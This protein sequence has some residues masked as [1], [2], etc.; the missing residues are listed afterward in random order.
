MYD[1]KLLQKPTRGDDAVKGGAGRH[2]L[3]RV[4]LGSGKVLPLAKRAKGGAAEHEAHCSYALSV[5]ATSVDKCVQAILFGAFG[6]GHDGWTSELERTA[7]WPTET[8]RFPMRMCMSVDLH[9]RDISSEGWAIRLHKKLV[10]WIKRSYTCESH[11]NTP[12]ID[13]TSACIWMKDA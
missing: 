1:V 8:G 5:I 13:R 6:E 7:Q 10:G 2:Y 11:I 3:D 9:R 4:R 12:S